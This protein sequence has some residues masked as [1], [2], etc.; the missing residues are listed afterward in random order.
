MIITYNIKLV[1]FW[2]IS[3]FNLCFQMKF[4]LI[5]LLEPFK[6]LPLKIS[7]NPRMIRIAHL[8]PPIVHCQL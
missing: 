6:D 4:Y 5:I 1:I 7:S 2:W 8:L 3:Y